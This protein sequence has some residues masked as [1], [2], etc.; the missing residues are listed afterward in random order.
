MCFSN[1]ELFECLVKFEESKAIERTQ[2]FCNFKICKSFQKKAVFEF[3]P[4]ERMRAQ[5]FENEMRSELSEI[6]S[7]VKELL[8]PRT[9][10]LVPGAAQVTPSAP[11]HPLTT[12]DLAVTPN[13][14]QLQ[15]I[16]AATPERVRRS[17]EDAAAA[18]SEFSEDDEDDDSW[19]SGKKGAGSPLPWN[20]CLAQ[21]Y[22][23]LLQS[24]LSLHER[25]R[26]LKARYRALE[27]D[28]A[29]WK[30]DVNG[31]KQ[32]GVQCAEHQVLASVKVGSLFHEFHI[33][34]GASKYEPKLKTLFCKP[35]PGFAR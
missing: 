22:R 26:S 17:P 19:A 27:E 20:D 13:K 18:D 15:K 28:R 31:L 35:A 6:K 5:T 11:G 16:S 2:P 25:K 10:E 12:S 14:Q 30:T 3:G 32:M 1:I 7:Q 29:Q 4:S 9:Q 34:D 24:K 33:C 23:V 8:T 21:E